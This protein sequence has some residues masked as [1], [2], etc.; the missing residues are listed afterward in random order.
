[1]KTNSLLLTC[2]IGMALSGAVL[3]WLI[4]PLFSSDGQ[5]NIWIMVAL[6]SLFIAF[7]AGAWYAKQSIPTAD[8][9]R[10]QSQM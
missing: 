2:I 7:A 9:D 10:Q 3:I 1:M 6:G 8:A 4:P 5:S